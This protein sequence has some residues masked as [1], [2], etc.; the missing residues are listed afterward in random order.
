MKQLYLCR[1][2]SERNY[3]H[4]S[5]SCLSRSGVGDF[6]SLCNM[7]RAEDARGDAH[8][9]K[10]LCNIIDAVRGFFTEI[11][12]RTIQG[13]NRQCRCFVKVFESIRNF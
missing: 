13:T 7:V 10:E 12:Q 4:I 9:G 11:Q 5:K 2:G 3:K 6:V 1:Y 8:K